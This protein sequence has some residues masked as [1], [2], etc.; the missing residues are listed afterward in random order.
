M[1][2]KI[3][4]GISVVVV[5]LA[6]VISLIITRQR[7]VDTFFK[8][9]VDNITKITITCGYDGKRAVVQEPSALKK[10]AEMIAP[11][12]VKPLYFEPLRD[13]WSYSI[14][15]YWG[16]KYMSYVTGP[17]K[18]NGDDYQYVGEY[19]EGNWRKDLHEYL[20]ELLAK[21]EIN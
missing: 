10:L 7:T 21:Y 19:A 5:L 2:K 14:A 4:I 1:K 18:I 15:V 9:S 20:E 12:E 13:G 16:D 6:V 11:V 8:G 3:I 17:L